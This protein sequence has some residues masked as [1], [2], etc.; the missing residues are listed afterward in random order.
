MFEHLIESLVTIM[1]KSD[2]TD[3]PSVTDS[4]TPHGIDVG[5]RRPR[6]TTTTFLDTNFTSAQD[7]HQETDHKADAPSESPE[8]DKS[9]RHGSFQA[10]YRRSVREAE[11]FE[12]NYSAEKDSEK[13]SATQNSQH[14]NEL[15]LDQVQPEGLTAQKQYDHNNLARD[16]DKRNDLVIENVADVAKVDAK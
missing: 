3:H 6:C 5:F 13:H 15:P 8:V 9:A 16:L 7:T 2:I 12:Q 4:L 1:G 10:K 11:K 14:I